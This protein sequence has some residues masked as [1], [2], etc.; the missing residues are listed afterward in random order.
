MAGSELTEI[1]IT[2]L[3]SAP[4]IVIR[5]N[6]M[7]IHRWFTGLG[8]AFNVSL[9]LLAIGEPAHA[10]SWAT[11]IDENGMGS[12]AQP[13][14]SVPPVK[15]LFT[16]A[17]DP[18]NL[19]P[20]FP[21]FGPMFYLDPNNPASKNFTEQITLG[22]LVILEPDG[23]TIS[24]VVRFEHI[25][26]LPGGRHGGANAYFFYSDVDGDKNKSDINLL[27]LLINPVFMTE[28]AANGGTITYNPTP[29]QPGGLA[30][31]KGVFA[32]FQYV[33]KSECSSNGICSATPEPSMLPVLAASSIGLLW[34]DWRGRRKLIG[35]PRRRRPEQV[36]R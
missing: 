24:D 29:K 30:S 32:P 6:A 25:E 12:F 17:F 7:R 19:Y 11:T 21:A 27:P 28:T 2:H 20:P 18:F 13:G 9:L 14:S 34:Y 1:P 35:M 4:E 36:T 15:L 10:T 33:I 16:Y 5:N 3:T 31:G 8:T 22:D 23:K 26:G